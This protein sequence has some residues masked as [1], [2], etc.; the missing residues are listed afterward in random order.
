MGRATLLGQLF[1]S[2]PGG[3]EDSLPAAAGS[4]VASFAPNDSAF[5][6]PAATHIAQGGAGGVGIGAH[7]D[8]HGCLWSVWRV[9]FSLS[10]SRR[11][12]TVYRSEERRVGKECRSWGSLW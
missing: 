6:A 5:A 2:L 8:L 1:H 3:E 10:T 4:C 11:A 12:G 9:P 7:R